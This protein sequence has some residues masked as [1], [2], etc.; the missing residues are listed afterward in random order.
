[1]EAGGSTPLSKE[2]SKSRTLRALYFSRSRY[3]RN[4]LPLL[5]SESG[6][7]R[8]AKAP[9]DLGSRVT[10]HFAVSDA[11][12]G[13]LL[14]YP[15]PLVLAAALP[16]PPPPRPPPHLPILRRSL[17]RLEV[18]PPLARAWLPEVAPSMLP[19]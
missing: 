18:L 7:S 3:R 13:L 2:Y 4:R 10:S 19:Q 17:L 16:P 11:P 9:H 6:S 5:S 8:Q 1:M 12:S 15:S 14:S